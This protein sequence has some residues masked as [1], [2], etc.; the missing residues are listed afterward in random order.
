MNFGWL[1]FRAFSK[2]GTGGVKRQLNLIRPFLIGNVGLIVLAA[3][4]WLYPVAASWADNR[5]LIS[6]QRHVYAAYTRQAAQYPGILEAAAASHTGRILYYENLAA[7]MADIYS[8]AGYHGLEATQFDSTEWL[9]YGA[10]LDIGRF[11]ERQVSAI[12][13]GLPGQMSPFIYGLADSAAFIRNVRI[14]F[15]KD[16]RANLRVEF[17]L[18]ARE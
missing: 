4:F 9:D 17:S 11:F 15:L 12:F 2:S 6:R 18:L 3:I 8:L 10:G 1:K 7:A 16:G 5:Q 14:D 13:T